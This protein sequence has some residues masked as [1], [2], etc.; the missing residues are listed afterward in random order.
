VAEAAEDPFPWD[1]E[2]FVAVVAHEAN[3]APA[4]TAQEPPTTTSEAPSWRDFTNALQ[5]AL[6]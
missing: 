6:T 5:E 2:A 4:P 1:A 3:N